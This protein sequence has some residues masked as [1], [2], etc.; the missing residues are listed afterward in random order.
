MWAVQ[1][2]IRRKIQF[3]YPA[4]RS[5]SSSPLTP[6]RL[7][8]QLQLLLPCHLLGRTPSCTTHVPPFLSAQE[9]QLCPGEQSGWSFCF[10]LSP[11][12]AGLCALP[13]KLALDTGNAK[14]LVIF[15]SW[16]GRASQVLARNFPCLLASMY[17]RLGFWTRWFLY[18][19]FF[20]C[21]FQVTGFCPPFS[22]LSFQV[23]KGLLQLKPR[24]TPSPPLPPIAWHSLGFYYIFTAYE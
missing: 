12:A 21:S 18:F 4:V 23:G 8:L 15:R 3:Q 17:C 14:F 20:I 7:L 16:A 19:F 24:T 6:C 9:L 22:S 13:V 1:V 10:F 5:V 2:L 11:S